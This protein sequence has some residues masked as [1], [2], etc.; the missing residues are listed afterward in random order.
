MMISTKL[1]MWVLNL[2]NRESFWMPNVAQVS[3]T[4]IILRTGLT[5]CRQYLT[6]S[7]LSLIVWELIWQHFTSQNGK[8]REYP[9]TMQN[10]LGNH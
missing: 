3:N 4:C 9:Q 6:D 10:F 8:A 7:K 2:R 5:L 1:E